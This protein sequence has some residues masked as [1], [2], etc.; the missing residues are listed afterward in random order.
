MVGYSQDICATIVSVDISYH[1]I[2][3]ETYRGPV[4][5]EITFIFM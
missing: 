4:R 5:L 2:V 3:I 1:L